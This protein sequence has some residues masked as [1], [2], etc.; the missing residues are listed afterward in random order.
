MSLARMTG[1]DIATPKVITAAPSASIAKIVDSMEN[2]G[3]KR[4]VVER[5][6]RGLGMVT[7]KDIVRFASL[8]DTERALDEITVAEVMSKPLITVDVDAP[9]QESSELMLARG[10][11]STVLTDGKRMRGILTK[12]DL[13]RY[14]ALKLGR[15]YTVREFM[16]EKLFTVEPSHSVFYAARHMMDNK[17][18]RL[19]VVEDGLKGIVTYSDLFVASP[20]LRSRRLEGEEKFYRDR[21]FIT[22]SRGIVS[23][24]VSD[25]MTS[26][27][28]TITGD[29]GLGEAARQMQFYRISGL[30]VVDAR[31]GLVGIVTKTD[32]VRAIATR[33]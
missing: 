3:I 30:P 18:S 24:K 7:E 16:T 14:A 5:G 1:R 31:L 10:I 19:P 27:P 23:L 4:V 20:A 32:V 15:R 9:V 21:G 13:C 29:Q 2:L 11:S 6:G 12:T 26:H 8:D 28:L 25:V 33:L 22:I 17:V